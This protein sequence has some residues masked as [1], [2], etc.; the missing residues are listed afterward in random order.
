MGLRKPARVVL[1]GCGPCALRNYV[2]LLNSRAE[3]VGVIDA[4]IDGGQV[5]LDALLTRLDRTNVERLIVTHGEWVSATVSHATRSWL[6]R[7]QHERQADSVVIVAEARCHAAYVAVA[8]ELGYRVL[9]DK[10]VV[11][12]R[13]RGNCS[14]QEMFA[15][16]EVLRRQAEDCGAAVEVMAQR[17][18]HAGYR[19]LFDE[20]EALVHTYRVPVTSL[21]IS[22]CD[23]DMRL[24]WEFRRENHPFH[25]GY[26]VLHHSGYHFVDTIARLVSL[27]DALD[28]APDSVEVRVAAT[29]L[30]DLLAQIPP[31]RYQAL[32][33]EPEPVPDI[34][35]QDE[36]TGEVD[37]FAQLRFRRGADVITTATLNLVHNGF[38]RRGWWQPDPDTYFGNGRVK[39]ERVAV[40]MGPL[41]C[42]Q[43]HSYG[44]AGSRGAERTDAQPAQF[45]TAFFRNR[46]LVGGNTLQEQSFGASTELMQQARENCLAAFLS[47][48]ASCA[49]L[50]MHRRTNLLMALLSEALSREA[51]AGFDAPPSRASWS[52]EP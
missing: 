51:A 30:N 39:H 49:S 16:F 45:E 50:T 23:G 7:L 21:E 48:G 1:I 4:P 36:I 46:G 3:V 31:Q 38:S 19:A 40:Q 28:V 25:H 47:G 13:S 20:V 34:P 11:V 26:G 8:I 41:A 43:C 42:C 37:L 5:R 9:V 15:E 32:L 52:L 14:W 18:Y 10:P 24:P 12:P 2:P 29:R 6:Q 27:N 33:P 17:R 44:A 35:M 22:Y